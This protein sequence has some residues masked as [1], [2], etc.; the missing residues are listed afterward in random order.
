MSSNTQLMYNPPHPGRLV[1]RILIKS[2]A[3]TVTEAAAALGVGRITLSKIINEKSGISPQMAIRLSLYLNTS[4]EMW[5][6]M[7]NMYDLWQAERERNKL[8]RVIKPLR[9]VM[10][11]LEEPLEIKKPLRLHHKSNTARCKKVAKH[12]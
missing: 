4:S 1:K 11:S 6:G 3:L 10:G 9:K 8:R 12:A 5:L 7:Q 2:L